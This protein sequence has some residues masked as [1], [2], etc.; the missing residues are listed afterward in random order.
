MI[1]NKIKQ[2]KGITL[3]ILVITVIVMLIITGTLVYNAQDTAQLKKLTNLYN[4]IELLEEKV[5]EYYNEYGK[6]PAKILT[7]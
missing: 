1:K 7:P 5:S 6:I 4:D 2:E 3:S